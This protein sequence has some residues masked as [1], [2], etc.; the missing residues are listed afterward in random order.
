MKFFKLCLY[1]FILVFP[2]LGCG[3][4]ATEPQAVEQDE[5]SRYLE[6][7]PEADVDYPEEEYSSE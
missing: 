3:G 1:L 7:N 4:G 6:D 5:L 2:V